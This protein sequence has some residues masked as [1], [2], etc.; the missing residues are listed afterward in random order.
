MAVKRLKAAI[1]DAQRAGLLG[2]NVG[3]TS[4]SFDLE[5]RLGAGAFVCGEETALMA[6]IEGGRGAPRPR[7]PF[8]GVGLWGRPTLIDNVETMASIAP[9][10]FK[11]ADWYASIGTTEKSKGTKVFALTG[12]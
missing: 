8:P 5:V 3:G 11:G 9:I 10:I 4:F 12:R 2:N 1:K 6:S 7:P